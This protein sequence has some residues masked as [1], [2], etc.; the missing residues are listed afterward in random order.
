M[1][2][3]SENNEGILDFPLDQLFRTEIDLSKLSL[4]LGDIVDLTKAL[5]RLQKKGLIRIVYDPSVDQEPLV[6]ITEKGTQQA[7]ELLLS[8]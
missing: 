6:R 3:N 2:E 7:L 5:G 4:K 8:L 1:T